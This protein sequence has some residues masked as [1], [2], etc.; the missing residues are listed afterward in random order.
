MGT[1][2]HARAR[3][4]QYVQ[5]SENQLLLFGVCDPPHR[6][7][8]DSVT[9]VRALWRPGLNRRARVGHH[10][11]G[12]RRACGWGARR[13]I[14][15]ATHTV[16]TGPARDAQGSWA[17]RASHQRGGVPGADSAGERRRRPRGRPPPPHKR[18]RNS[19]SHTASLFAFST[20]STHSHSA[21]IAADGRE[22]GGRS[23]SGGGDALP[24]R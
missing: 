22:R 18:A 24:L 11:A 2:V 15:A 1:H 19:F 14:S 17:G 16:P 7:T 8:F 23:G 3:A 6:S 4:G 12:M 13:G 5:R 10:I 21:S 9:A 20:R